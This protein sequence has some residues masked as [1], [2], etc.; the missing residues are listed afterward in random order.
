MWVVTLR[1]ARWMGARLR[2]LPATV[3]RSAPRARARQIQLMLP[4]SVPLASSQLGSIPP[5][6]TAAISIFHSF[7]TCH[8][9]KPSPPSSLNSPLERI[10]F[11]LQASIHSVA[12]RLMSSIRHPVSFIN[13]CQQFN[14]W[15]FTH[16]MNHFV[17][18]IW[19]T[20][21]S[22]RAKESQQQVTTHSSRTDECRFNNCLETDQI[23]AGT[24]HHE[25]VDRARSTGGPQR[26]S[27][28]ISLGSRRLWLA[29]E[30]R[31]AVASDAWPCPSDTRKSR[32]FWRCLATSSP[33]EWR[34]ISHQSGSNAAISWF[35][36]DTSASHLSQV[37]DLTLLIWTPRLRWTPEQAAAISIQIDTFQQN[38]IKFPALSFEFS[39]TNLCIK[40]CRCWC[41]PIRDCRWNNRSTSRCPGR[42]GCPS[43]FSAVSCA[44]YLCDTTK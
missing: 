7:T 39:C 24:R 20:R 25:A 15:P 40:W 36:W 38:W 44:R 28:R 33:V 34:Q 5:E 43:G 14:W 41:W 16:Y 1:T 30:N 35:T 31:V 26:V 18:I 17:R 32:W 8:V 23:P 37:R 3:L 27:F 12:I 6:I 29:G 19:F 11:R 9:V 21:H 42:W 4:V 10:S 13:H 22:W 2:S